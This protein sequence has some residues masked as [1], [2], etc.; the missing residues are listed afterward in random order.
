MN[1]S[2]L[3]RKT[4]NEWKKIRQAG[5]KLAQAQIKLRVEADVLVEVL[6]VVIV[7]VVVE[8]GVR[9]FSNWVGVLYEIKVKL[10]SGCSWS[11]S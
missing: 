7:D 4:S 10:N 2:F 3:R 6:V 9:Y 5:P 11:W 1:H 8:V